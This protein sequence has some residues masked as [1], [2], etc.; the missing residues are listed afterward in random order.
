MD[1]FNSVKSGGKDLVSVRAHKGDA[2]TLLAFDL[3]K[4]LKS[5]FAGFTIAFKVGTRNSVVYNKIRFKDDIALPTQ[6]ATERRKFSSEFAP[7]Q[8][9]RWIHVPST[10]DFINNPIFGDYTYTVTPRWV[11]NKKLLALD[12]AFSVRVKID[13]SPFQSGDVKIGFTRSFISSQSYAYNFGNN[14]RMRPNRTDLTFDITQKSGTGTRWNAQ[15]QQEEP[16]DYSF[17]EQHQYLGWQARDRAMEI[18]DEVLGDNSLRLDVFAYDLNEPTIVSKLIELAKQGRLRIILD[19]YPNH[20]KPD[21]MEEKFHRLFDQEAH[22]TG[23]IFRGNYDSQAHSKV[24]IVRKNNAAAKAVKVLTGSLNFTT[25]GV[26][27][28]ANHTITFENAEV[29]QLFADAFDAS[30]GGPLMNDFK[31]HDIAMTDHEFGGNGLPEMTIRISPHTKSIVEQFFGSISQRILDAESDVLFAIMIDNSKS[32]ILDA[33]RTQVQGDAVFT[34]GITDEKDAIQLYKP[35]SKVGVKISAKDIETELPPPFNKIVKIG[36][37][38][39]VIHHKF[40]VVDF[41]GA[42]P[43]VYCGSSNLA[44]N[45]EQKNGDN[46]LEIRD[47][48]IATV[49][50]VEAIRLIDHF[51]WLNRKIEA[52]ETNEPFNLRDGREAKKWYAAYYKP[53][54]LRFVERTLLISGT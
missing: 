4:S 30:Y 47:R 27:I 10:Q 44:F 26:Y 54:D 51:H 11:K 19:N 28:N 20:R 41:K 38:G 42:N 49:F 15:T 14:L 2:M 53:N 7:I 6:P 40:V 39:H 35:E 37:F 45:P 16:T 13:V 25:N 17:E 34:Y 1:V 12:P 9:Y 46:L 5:G 50:A 31:N 48:D 22:D 21:C 43:V 3:D 18:L 8:K 29:A 52:D 36:A 24:F 33:V 32:G 23:H